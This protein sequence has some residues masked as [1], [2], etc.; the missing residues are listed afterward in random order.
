TGVQTCALPILSGAPFTPVSC[1]K[2]AEGEEFVADEPGGEA[3]VFR[4]GADRAEQS[5]RTAHRYVQRGLVGSCHKFGKAP[6]EHLRIGS[7][8]NGYELYAALF[9]HFLQHIHFGKS[10]AR[11]EE[12]EQRHPIKAGRFL[13]S[14]PG[15]K[16]RYAYAAAD[17]DFVGAIRLSL[18]A[19]I[20]G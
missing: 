10:A 2:S 15:D 17:P 5:L 11:C 4:A 16:G 18:E 20:G 7:G 3:V 19:A 14:Q 13:V 9:S 12:I 1:G 8:G 6:C